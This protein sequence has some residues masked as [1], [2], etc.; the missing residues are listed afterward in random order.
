[1]NDSTS[2]FPGKS[3]LAV[4]LLALLNFGCMS[5]ASPGESFLRLEFNGIHQCS[6]A[7][8]AKDIKPI[9]IRNID[10]LPNLDR[11]AVMFSENNVL[12]PSQAWYWEGAPSEIV[13]QYLV[14]GLTC[15]KAFRVVW[16]YKPRIAH[17]A[18]LSGRV[19]A[20][21]VSRT[22]SLAF[23]VVIYM[24]VWGPTAKEWISGRSFTAEIP[25]STITA[26]NIAKAANKALDKVLA[27]TLTWLDNK[28]AI[29]E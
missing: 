17:E 11:T 5:S 10:C 20:F 29:A 28:V 27:D 12:Q 18:V 26:D 14:T 22:P 6:L 9:A 2:R 25:M 15:S 19:E 21:E 7:D 3:I 4:C 8:D 13:T 24:D 16:P 1:M 23:R